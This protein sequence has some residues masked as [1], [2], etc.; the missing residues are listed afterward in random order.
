M[1]GEFSSTTHNLYDALGVAPTAES[2]E[3]RRAFRS[4]A[5]LLHPDVNTARDAAQQF[6]AV[7]HAHAVLSDPAR[8][9]AYDATR[10]APPGV[11]VRRPVDA[12]PAFAG[13]GA[14]RGADVAV[15]VRLSLREAAFGSEP[16]VEVP[17]REVCAICLG[18]GAPEDGASER[19][20]VCNG[21]GGTRTPGN[22]CTACQ[23]S[24][25]IGDPPCPNCHGTSRKRGR[26][27]LSVAIPAGIEHGSR[28][29][30][31]GDGDVGPRNGP[32]GALILEVEVE[33]D[34]VL[35]RSGIDI[36]MDLPI[37]PGDAASGC[38]IE[39]PTLRGPKRLHVPPHTHDRALLRLGGAGVRPH[40]SWHRGDQ[41]VTVVVVDGQPSEP[42]SR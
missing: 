41:F 21:T 3:I 37:S 28:L 2:D 7:A 15:T 38:M 31:R 17:R 29:T 27:T 35:R 6:A 39:V 19:C 12:R 4:L 16:R 8:R 9:R 22:E 14:L 24:G 13:R 1:D 33:S 11:R 30:L 25:V 23:G 10:R 42:A 32:R 26:T 20:P 36:L 34:P 18:R 40:G 5:R